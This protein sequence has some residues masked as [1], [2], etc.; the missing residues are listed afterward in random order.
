VKEAVHREDVGRRMTGGF[1]EE[2]G[3]TGFAIPRLKCDHGV[4]VVVAVAVARG[5]QLCGQPIR[6]R[7]V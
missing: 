1:L 7:Q 3:W 4:F 6:L 5:S 2:V